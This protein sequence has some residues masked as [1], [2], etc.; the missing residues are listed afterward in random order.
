LH[1]LFA[2][3]RIHADDRAILSGIS[4]GGMVSVGLVPGPAGFSPVQAKPDD[5]ALANRLLYPAFC[6]AAGSGARTD[7]SGT[8]PGNSPLYTVLALAAGRGIRHGQFHRRRGRL[9][10]L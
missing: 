5:S 6:S 7:L 1:L 9:P 8:I 4:L 3:R 10:A 2:Q